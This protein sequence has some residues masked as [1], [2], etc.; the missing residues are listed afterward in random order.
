ME[1]NGAA[2]VERGH[3]VEGHWQATAPEAVLDRLDVAGSSGLTSAAA[4]ARLERDG[5]NRLPVKPPPGAIEIGVRQLRS[6]LIY[7]L[8]AAAGASLLI[9]ELGDAAFIAIVLAINSAV[10]GWQEWRA[11]QQ[12][13]GLQKL[14]QARATVLRDGQLREVD[15]ADVVQGDVVALESGQRVA[16]DARLLVAQGLEI[17]EALLTGESLP[18]RKDASWLGPVDADPSDCLNMTYAGS[19]VVRGRGRAVVVAT[20]AATHVGRLAIAITSPDAGN[21]P[22]VERMERFSRVIAIAVLLAATLIG[23]VA[24]LLHDVSIGTMLMF[25]I[26]LAVSAI[27]EGL[28]V[29]ITIALAVAARRMASRGAIVRRLP[30]VEGLGSCTLI[31]SDKTGTLTCNELTACEAY[32]ADGRRCRVTGG[33]YRPDGQIHD[34]A[35]RSIDASDLALRELLEVAVACNEGD[36]RLQHGEWA[37]RGDP[38]DVALLTLAAKGRCEREPLLESRP[39]LDAV[40]FEPERRYA[41]SVHEHGGATWTAVKGAPEVV[42][43]M[44]R[45]SA[46]RRENAQSAAV[47][48]ASRGQRVLA[49]A[50]GMRA[51]TPGGATDEVP[52]GDLD[53]VGL[54]GRSH[55]AICA[56]VTASRWNSTCP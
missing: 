41:V 5:P 22:L 33:G 17:D 47:D 4:A 36:L 40:P 32:L 6:P 24:V 35:G 43:A 9:G 48:M 3:R 1:S 16:A 38:T 46:G 44:C 11:E 53:F 2:T 27:P 18:V 42:L 45:M 25:G 34:D 15:A 10:G 14:L 54:V 23:T 7:V 29:A 39:R 31:A 49:L 37:W 56:G 26:A 51:A 30:A 50:S 8:L 21:P 12:R 19:T 13:H 55:S 20:G 52:P 28:P